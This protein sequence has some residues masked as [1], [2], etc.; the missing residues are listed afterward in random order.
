[1][2]VFHEEQISY[3]PR[4][5]VVLLM[6]SL[7][8]RRFPE[9]GSYW[10]S[11]LR[12]PDVTT[13][14]TSSHADRGDTGEFRR[15]GEKGPAVTSVGVISEVLEDWGA[16]KRW[17]TMSHYAV[18]ILSP[19]QSKGDSILVKSLPLHSLEAVYKLLVYLRTREEV[20]ENRQA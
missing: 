9:L 6:Q 18:P 17:P 5:S 4:L 1:M 20:S 10:P 7:V 8:G 2:I 3:H 11:D 19:Q 14:D 16:I 13:D 12:R 15:E